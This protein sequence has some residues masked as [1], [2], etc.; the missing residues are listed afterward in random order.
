MD[1]A[2][3]DRAL[4]AALSVSPSPE[5]VAR[6]RSKIAQPDSVPFFTG[7]IK[8][9]AVAVSLGALVL[10]VAYRQTPIETVHSVT[11]LSGRP[12]AAVVDP[13][14]VTQSHLVASPPTFASVEL[15]S[16]QPKMPEVIIAPDSRHA[17]MELLENARERR[18]E[19]TFD[20]TPPSAPWA[21]ND[22]S[23]EPL[24]IEPLDPP[25]ANNN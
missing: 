1:D 12:F 10:A 5:F 22:L 23:V 24:V 21:M 11:T 7:W 18:F 15:S 6:V 8:P 25:T 20:E 3:L 19:A 16:S 2:E 4:N 9:I 13:P 14:R 17:L